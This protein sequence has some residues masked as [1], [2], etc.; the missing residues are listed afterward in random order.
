MREQDIIELL[1]QRNEK[2]MDALLLHYGPLMRY[3]IAPI[4]PDAQ[5]Q[6]DCLSEAAMQVWNKI[7]RF[8]SHRGSWNAWLTAITRNYAL[9]YKRKTSLHSTVD[10]IPSDLP[11]QELTP[12]EQAIQNERQTA[13]N[14]ALQRLPTKDRILFYRKYY[15]MQSTAQIASETGMTERAVEGRLYRIK[16]Q[17]RRRLGGEK[18]EDS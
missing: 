12:E 17:L 4:L 14:L 10:D 16:K 3:I 11:S 18:Y 1:L 7:E 2:G 8:D 15:Y 5:A 9:N 6:E 13:V